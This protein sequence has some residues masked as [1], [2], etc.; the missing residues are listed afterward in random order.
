MHKNGIAQIEIQGQQFAISTLPAI[1][2]LKLIAYDDRPENRGKDLRDIGNI[3][4][5]YFYIAGE[6]VFEEEFID[7]I[8]SDNTLAASAQLL[9]RHIYLII[10][11]SLVLVER[12]MLILDKYHFYMEYIMHDSRIEIP[13]DVLKEI[14]AG[15]TTS[16]NNHL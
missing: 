1:V 6:D 7:L 3:V 15:I 11:Y 4:Q 14:R 16:M 13:T 2:L 8:D 9:G 10:K 5:H 12:V